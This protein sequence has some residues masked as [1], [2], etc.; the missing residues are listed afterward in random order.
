MWKSKVTIIAAIALSF[1]ATI[2]ASAE[3]AP[4]GSY[5][6]SCSQI[7]MENGTLSAICKTRS[8]EEVGSY[9]AKADQCKGDI[10]NWNGQLSCQEPGGSWSQTCTNLAVDDNSGVITAE[11]RRR[12][13][14]VNNAS[15]QAA[16]SLTNC[17]GNLVLADS[18]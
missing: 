16:G 3:D 9:L 4:N 18:C 1:G 2:P 11:C 15:T 12:D 13:Q 5:K 14:S 6:D 7:A 10:P 8:A 17:N